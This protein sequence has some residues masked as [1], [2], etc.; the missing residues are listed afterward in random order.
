MFFN[1]FSSL[2]GSKHKKMVKQWKLEHEQIAKK[3]TRVLELCNQNDYKSAKK[4]FIAL[5]DLATNHLVEEDMELYKVLKDNKALEKDVNKFKESFL[6]IKVALIKFLTHYSNPNVA[7]DAEFEKQ[8][9]GILG[10]LGERID[11][12]ETNLYKKIEI[13]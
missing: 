13:L 12:E 3:A 5:N 6:D 8:L 7:L 11:F 10:V 4:E 9:R 1:F 2:F